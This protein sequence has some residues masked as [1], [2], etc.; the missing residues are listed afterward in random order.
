MNTSLKVM[1][2]DDDSTALTVASAV[3]DDRGYHIV[4]RDSALGT[5]LA[6]RREKPDIVLLDVNMPG[7]NGDALTKLIVETKG[8]HQPIII[9]HSTMGA[10]ELGRLAKACG[11][12]GGIEKTADPRELLKRFESVV[13]QAQRER[14]KR[15]APSTAQK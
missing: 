14:A 2:V 11:A 4:T 12:A 1:I 15:D 3:L 10:D 9:L 5:V 6:V 13:S 8:G 7:L